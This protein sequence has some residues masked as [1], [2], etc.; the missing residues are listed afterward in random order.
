MAYTK[1]L[2]D[3]AFLALI[4]NKELEIVGSNLTYEKIKEDYKKPINEQLYSHWYWDN[5]FKTYEQFLEW[6]RFYEDIFYKWK[7]KRYN[8]RRMEEI[9][10]YLNL[11]YGLAYDFEFPRP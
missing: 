3:D 11:M 6:K 4:I 5:K 1:K 7:P 10:A 2:T 9:F 8:K